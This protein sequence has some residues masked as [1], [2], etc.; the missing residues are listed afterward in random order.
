[1]ICFDK[2]GISLITIF[3]RKDI[4]KLKFTLQSVVAF[5][6][7]ID[8]FIII[9]GEINQKDKIKYFINNSFAKECLNKFKLIIE[10]DNGVSHAFNKGIM[11]SSFEFLLFCNAGDKL[12]DI[13]KIR[14]DDCIV[15]SSFLQRKKN[16]LKKLIKPFQ[17]I[18]F[19]NKYVH[20]G[21]IIS[22]NTFCQ[23]GLFESKYKVAMDYN[24]FC[25]ARRNDIRFRIMDSPVV[26][27][28]PARLSGEKIT[29]R[30]FYEPLI[31]AFN[32][33]PLKLI[34]FLPI[35]LTIFLYKF[36]KNIF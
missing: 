14:E 35:Y 17:D 15:M 11:Y 21:C 5:I 28:E 10:N 13:P 19:P 25:K 3:S 24:F 16:G 9:G 27:M 20:P 33:C 30:Q 29:W 32:F 6:D 23:I 1:M 8:E 2:K 36:F 26:E 12:L 18:S 31:I 34:K 4:K 7:A 22:K